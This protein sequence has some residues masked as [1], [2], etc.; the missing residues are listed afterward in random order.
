MIIIYYESK[1][2]RYC[3]CWK[4]QRNLSRFFCFFKDFCSIKF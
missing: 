4:N 2:T 3:S 1:Y